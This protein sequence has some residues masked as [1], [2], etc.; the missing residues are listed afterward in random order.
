[1]INLFIEQIIKDPNENAI[2]K[3]KLEV[4][5]WIGY[6]L[7]GTATNQALP[8]LNLQQSL[9]K[10]QSLNLFGKRK[11]NVFDSAFI[12]AS[13][14]NI[15]ELDD[16]HRTSI[17]HPGDTVIPAAIATSSF[18]NI[19]TLN[20]LKAIIIGYETAIR[21][22]I[23]LG[24]DHYKTFYSSATCGVFGAAAASSYILNFKNKD[25]TLNKNLNSSIQLATMT[26]SGVWQCRKG[27]GE[28]KQYALANACRAGVTAAFL[29]QNGA[30]TPLDMIE[31]ELGF[32]KGYKNEIDYKE[33]IQ[34]NDNHLINDISN[35][36]WPACRHSHPVIGVSLDLKKELLKNN[37]QISQI[38]EIVIETYKTAIDFCDKIKPK[39]DIEGK[40]SLQHCCAI[41]LNYG[42]ILEDYF[43]ENILNDIEISEIRE[44]VIIKNNSEMTDNFPNNYSASLLIKL[45]DGSIL[46]KTNLNAKGDP[47]NPMTEKEICDK[48][49]NLINSNFNGLENI[50]LLIKNIIS[51]EGDSLEK[52][53]N[54]FDDLQKLINKGTKKC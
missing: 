1:M 54:W 30:Q 20:F 47:E 33:L 24:E 46:K 25:Q 34:P 28:A 53:L 43:K 22:G 12:N 36:P 42:D 18:V 35:K 7:A 31:G 9:P 21:M 49:F 51:N 41:S 39:N 17:I 13:V 10:G 48:T 27:D 26:S 19:D 23:C 52:K 16:V 2:L 4:V 14:G 37:I 3:A 5:D 50:D 38:S 29:S 6:A 15:L 45:K 8:F 44:K 40:F 11:L 32:L